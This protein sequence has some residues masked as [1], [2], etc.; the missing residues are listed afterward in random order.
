MTDPPSF[1]SSKPARI[2]SMSSS[3]RAKM[4][5]NARELSSL[6]KAASSSRRPARSFPSPF[7][8]RSISFSMDLKSKLKML[9]PFSRLWMSGQAIVRLDTSACN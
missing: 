2:I 1:P 3:S 5:F 7:E 4:S 8:A 9:S 6:A